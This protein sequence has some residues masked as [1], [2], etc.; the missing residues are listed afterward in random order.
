MVLAPIAVPGRCTAWTELISFVAVIPGSRDDLENRRGPS[1]GPSIA[2]AP[3]IGIVV[4]PSLPLIPPRSSRCKGRLRSSLRKRH[5]PGW[6][7][8]QGS[9]CATPTSLPFRP[10]ELPSDSQLSMIVLMDSR[11]GGFATRGVTPTGFL[12]RNDR[13]GWGDK[14]VFA[15]TP[16]NPRFQDARDSGSVESC[17][18]ICFENSTGGHLGWEACWAAGL[19]LRF[20]PTWSAS[21]SM[22]FSGSSWTGRPPGAPGGSA[23]VS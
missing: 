2:E 12:L 16:P 23:R 4:M 10:S 18:P 17:W 5:S 19:N 6:A 1:L 9:R 14:A 11:K 15:R 22:P 13:S 7:R 21:R 20:P 8:R 3:L